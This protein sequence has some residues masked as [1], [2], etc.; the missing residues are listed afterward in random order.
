[1]SAEVIQLAGVAPGQ[2]PS[3]VVIS[4]IERLLAE[5][6][7]GQIRSIAFVLVDADRV[8]TPGF[9]TSGQHSHEFVAGAL[10]LLRLVEKRVFG[11]D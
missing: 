6:R 11:D 3:E 7:T 9:A 1:M 10:R 4:A 8:I 5:A 2:E